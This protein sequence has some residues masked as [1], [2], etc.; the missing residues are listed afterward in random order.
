MQNGKKLKGW[1][2]ET[3]E[4]RVDRENLKKEI[5][6]LNTAV[7][8]LQIEVD[9]ILKALNMKSYGEEFR[10]RMEKAEKRQSNEI[11]L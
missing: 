1:V 3:S 10:E 9:R 4:I 8:K 7:K 2:K 5:D 6:I 11:I